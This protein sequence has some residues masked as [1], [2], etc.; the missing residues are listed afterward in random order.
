MSTTDTMPLAAMNDGAFEQ[1]CLRA[2]QGEKLPDTRDLIRGCPLFGTDVVADSA[3]YADRVMNSLA[4]P[5]D[6]VDLL[7]AL[8][9][10]LAAPGQKTFMAAAAALEAVGCA[11]PEPLRQVASVRFHFYAALAGSRASI[12]R[13]AAYA[14]ERAYEHGLA[15][16]TAYH[17]VVAAVAWLFAMTGKVVVP[18]TWSRVSAEAFLS[19]VTG[20]GGAGCELVDRMLR[21]RRALLSGF[22]VEPAPESHEA[23]GA[24]QAASLADMPPS[25]RSAL[26]VAR[27]VGN[28]TTVEGRR[29]AAEFHGCVGEPLALSPS[30]DLRQVRGRLLEAYPFVA[31]IVD[32]LLRP[33][34]GRPHAHLPPTILVGPTGSGKSTFAQALGDA[35]G[36]PVEVVPWAGST[37]LG[38]SARQWS[39]GEPSL[40]LS[41][42]RRYRHAGPAIVLD[43]LD[44]AF[45]CQALDASQAALEAFL[46]PMAARGFRDPYLE[47]AVDLSAVTWLA[48]ASDVSCLPPAIRERCRIISFPEPRPQDLRPL[49]N[50]MLRRLAS[51][52]GLHEQW[53]TPLDGVE[54]AALA[55]RWQGGSL[56]RLE[57]YVDEVLNLRGQPW[58]TH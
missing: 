55:S 51:R 4:P 46:D 29:I 16:A 48:T 41:L 26:V 12:S 9:E 44:A 11:M 42:I 27:A 8:E 13:V 31:P 50:A 10:V 53:A 40:P 36:L 38:G 14:V 32:T 47:A 39:T 37:M 19:Q 45:A 3:A 35:L 57:R 15:P 58:Q 56:R 33:L 22:P 49:G 17:H 18:P 43:G 23:A 7:T 20:Q 6:P 28:A 2:E 34:A 1:R 25:G 30:P 5:E 52:L 21:N 24:F 54:L